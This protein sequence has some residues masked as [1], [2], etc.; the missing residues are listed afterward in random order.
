M[1]PITKDRIALIKAGTEGVTPGP[2]SLSAFNVHRVIAVHSGPDAA[3]REYTDGRHQHGICVMDRE[4][5]SLE[6]NERRRHATHIANLDPD[7][8]SQL[9]DLATE[10][11]E[12]REL[13]ARAREYIANVEVAIIEDK[14]LK[15]RDAE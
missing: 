1:T 6:F 8:V 14:S 10:A 5:D 15:G 3:G 4:M 12:G 11:L 7:T 9:C 2:W 13:M